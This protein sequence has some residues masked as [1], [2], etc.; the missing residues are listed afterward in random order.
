LKSLMIF[1]TT[2]SS[3]EL[4]AL[5]VHKVI[6]SPLAPDELPP[7]PV[8]HPATSAVAAAAA[9]LATARRLVLNTT[10]FLHLTEAGL[11]GPAGATGY[12]GRCSW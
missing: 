9:T 10:G 5:C 8:A 7:L 2:S 1:L 4:P 12:D 3:A 11:A 6:V